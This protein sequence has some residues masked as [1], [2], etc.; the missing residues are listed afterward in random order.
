MTWAIVASARSL[1]ESSALVLLSAWWLSLGAKD[2]SRWHAT[3]TQLAS[4][5]AVAS[6]DLMIGTIDASAID[7]QRT[8][9]DR[10]VS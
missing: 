4:K 7:I 5:A 10:R 1:L 9:S 6:P 8:S 2:L 3:I